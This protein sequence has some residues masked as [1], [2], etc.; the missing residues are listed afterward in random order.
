L[1]EVFM[2]SFVVA[3]FT[4]ALL[5]CAGLAFAHHPFAAEYD[6][7]KPAQLEGKVTKVDWTNPHAF[8]TV[9]GKADNGKTEQWKVELGSPGAL[10]KHGWK[11]SAVKA[12]DEVSIKG[13]YA[14]D[15]SR[16]I[17]AEGVKLTKSGREL[18]AVS[19]YHE[20]KAGN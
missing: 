16:L 13:W 3:A 6:A 7:N 10:G 8:L 14:R 5:T 2:K 20:S 12:G 11:R 19:S 18:D 17:N 4:G 15:G 9:E 1:A